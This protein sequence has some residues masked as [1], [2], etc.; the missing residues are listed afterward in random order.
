V[1][2]S[3]L[4]RLAQQAIDA[5]ALLRR[6]ARLCGDKRYERT[7]PEAGVT[8][9]E[10]G[11]RDLCVG[12]TDEETSDVHRAACMARVQAMERRRANATLPAAKVLALVPKL[13]N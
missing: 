4:C 13:P 5:V 9:A 7:L 12:L 10:Q 8:S 6:L 11:T 1:L 2:D 3:Y